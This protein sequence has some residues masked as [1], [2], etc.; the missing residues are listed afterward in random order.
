MLDQ[1][2]NPLWEHD[3]KVVLEEKWRAANARALECEKLHNELSLIL[4]DHSS[5]EVQKLESIHST[6]MSVKQVASL[7]AKGLYPTGLLSEDFQWF[8]EQHT[9]NLSE[10][11]SQTQ[12][13]ISSIPNCP[14]FLYEEHTKESKVLITRI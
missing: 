13:K 9:I 5:R 7:A 2:K 14:E 11:L 8:A 1:A 4:N 10:A 12:E 3:P 6:I